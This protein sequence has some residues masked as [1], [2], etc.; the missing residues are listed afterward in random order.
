M[1]G[2]SASILKV[3]VGDIAEPAETVFESVIRLNLRV[4]IG[5]EK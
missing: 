3:L 2:N 5:A 4:S 1:V